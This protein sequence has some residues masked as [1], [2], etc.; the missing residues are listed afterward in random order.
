MGFLLDTNIVSELRKQ[1]RC[2]RSVREWYEAV[3]FEDIFL[4]VLVFGELRRGVENIRRRDAATAGVLERWSRG[5]RLAHVERILP[6]TL[7]I[8][9]LWGRLSILQPM[10]ITDGLLA[11]TAQHYGLTVATRNTRDFQR[12]GVDYI[13]P[14]E[15]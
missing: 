9:D 5:L 15:I 4:S 1:S 2:S 3:H 7:E 10:P 8:C 14:F 13:N 12:C 11:A 6:V